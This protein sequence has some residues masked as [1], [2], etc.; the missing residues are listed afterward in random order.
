MMSPGIEWGKQRLEASSKLN[1][2]SIS[3]VGVVALLL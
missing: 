3:E 1:G 2:S